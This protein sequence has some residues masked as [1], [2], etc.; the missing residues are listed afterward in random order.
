MT[1][2]VSSPE[3]TK[4]GGGLRWFL[5]RF[6][7]IIL[8]AC[9]ITHVVVIHFLGGEVIDFKSVVARI[10]SSAFWSVF[11]I[12]FLTSTLFHAL[13]GVYEIIEDYK[14]PRWLRISVIVIFWLA[15]LMATYWGIMTLVEWLS[16]KWVI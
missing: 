9:L 8:S 5:Q 3:H 12:V 11:Y 7:G 14:P 13:N 10:Q 15:G 4:S 1:E 6:T 16:R 2:I